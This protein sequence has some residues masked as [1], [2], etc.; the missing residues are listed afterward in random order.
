MASSA[1]AP[2]SI[3]CLADSDKEEEIKWKRFLFYLLAYCDTFHDFSSG[4]DK[5]SST[6]IPGRPEFTLKLID[7]MDPAFKFRNY[8]QKIQGIIKQTGDSSYEHAMYNAF[9]QLT[10]NPLIEI[11]PDGLA[12]Y[13]DPIKA[14]LISAFGAKDDTANIYEMID[15]DV[16]TSDMYNPTGSIIDFYLP[17][18]KLLYEP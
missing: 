18:P 5:L 11:I 7:H 15:S 6:E 4:R 17:K 9:T 8:Y 3:D 13:K 2:I 1:A 14:H 10:N 12:Q 16:F